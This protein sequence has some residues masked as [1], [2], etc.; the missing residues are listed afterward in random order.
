MRFVAIATFL[1]ALCACSARAQ[2]GTGPLVLHLPGSTRAL[3]LGGAYQVTST[4]ADA[5]FYN[6]VLLLSARGLGM[7][8]QRYDDASTLSTLSAAIDLNFGF[9]LQVLEYGASNFAFDDEIGSPAALPARGSLASGEVVG[10][11]GYARTIWKVRLGAAAKWAHHWGAGMTDGIAAFD[12]G[13]FVNPISWLTV[14]LAV[15]NLGGT[16][17]FGAHDYELPTRAVLN[18][19]TRTRVV[20]PLDV[21]LSG[22]AHKTENRDP[23]GGG[24]VE[25]SYWPVSGLTFFGRGGLRFGTLS[26]GP[27]EPGIEERPFTAGGGIT[28]NRISV[29]YAWEGFEGAPDAHRFG[30]R[31]R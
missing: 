15:Q 5:I 11:I 4:D 14:A 16:F 27:A 22:Y 30:L 1:G 9:G 6:P 2:E 19:A 26:A 18:V 29:D 23:A 13:S 8:V 31:L 28:F 10:T 7:S 20:G 24:G 3:A 21:S 25:V 17:E 12:V